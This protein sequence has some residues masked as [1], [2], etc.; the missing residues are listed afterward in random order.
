MANLIP[1]EPFRELADIGSIFDRFFG[2]MARRRPGLL[3][4]GFWSPAIDVYDQKDRIVVKAELPG[5]DK[6][7]VKVSVEGDVLSIRGETKKAQEVKEKDYYY[8]ERAYGSFY[9]ALPL[10]VTVEKEKVKASYKDGVLTIELPKTKE[11][12]AKETDIQIE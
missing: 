1:W 11:A 3:G 8:S 12:K 7:N 4:E 10:P 5:I 2:R 9:R 6:K